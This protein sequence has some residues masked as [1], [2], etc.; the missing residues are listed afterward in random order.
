MMGVFVQLNESSQ[1][2]YLQPIGYVIQENGCWDWVGSQVPEGYGQ[3]WC[4]GK[5]VRAHRF[6]Y[7][8]ANGPIPKGL[9]LDHLC[10]NR[11]CVNPDHLE[12]VTRQT[13]C[14]RGAGKTFAI[15]RSGACHRGHSNWYH[16]ARGGRLC[17]DCA[18]LRK[19]A[20]K[21]GVRLPRFEQKVFGEE[22]PQ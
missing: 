10:R 15:R 9:D 2:G 6:T 18:Y 17:R 8:A 22:T 14:H 5:L 13:N 19:K 12:A 16:T 7:E 21:D 1:R 11:A 4:G 20:K 3:M